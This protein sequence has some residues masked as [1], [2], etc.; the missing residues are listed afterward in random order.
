MASQRRPRRATTPVDRWGRLE[1]YVLRDGE[2]RWRIDIWADGR[3]TR[4]GH[5]NGETLTTRKQAEGLLEEIRDQVRA[6]APRS[7]AIGRFYPVAVKPRRYPAG[8]QEEWKEEYR[9]RMVS[10]ARR[11]AHAKGLP[12]DVGVEDVPVPTICPV[13]GIELKPTEGGAGRSDCAPSIERIDPALG[14]VRGNVV[15][16]SWRANKIK[17]DATAD[18]LRRI[19]DWASYLEHCPPETSAP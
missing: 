7:E 2:E 18:E 10:G 15:V 11:R 5:R 6:G 13:L 4:L 1:R 8:A 19:A 9:R 3:R 16:V 14:Y 12:F 17:G